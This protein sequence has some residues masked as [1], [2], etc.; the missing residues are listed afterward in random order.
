MHAPAPQGLTEA[1]ACEYLQR[2]RLVD[3]MGRDTVASVVR[4]GMS[5]AL[6]FPDGRL[7]YTLRVLPGRVL[8]IAAAAGP[9]RCATLPTLAA[10]ERQARTVGAVRLVFQT[11]RPGLVRLA[12][13]AGFASLLLPG[14]MVPGWRLEKALT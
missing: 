12:R 8:L 10:I 9:T 14:S 2:F 1:A 3:P 7:V 4:G 13:R 6:D 5:F 11:A